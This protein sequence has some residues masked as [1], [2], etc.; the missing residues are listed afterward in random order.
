MI[1][2]LSVCLSLLKS[3]RFCPPL[4]LAKRMFLKPLL[5]SK[6][7]ENSSNTDALFLFFSFFFLYIS[8]PKN[9]PLYV[10]ICNKLVACPGDASLAGGLKE[11]QDAKAKS[12][13]SQQK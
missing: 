12:E 4:S 8:L 1:T 13:A 2:L 9:T 11:V 5:P 6:V 3:F 7:Y 10:Y